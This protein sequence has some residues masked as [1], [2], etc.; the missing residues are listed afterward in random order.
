MELK[1][2]H[3]EDMKAQMTAHK[4]AMSLIQ[5]EADSTRRTEIQNL[6]QISQQEKVRM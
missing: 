3:I 5:N 4:A 1:T 6:Q 2:R